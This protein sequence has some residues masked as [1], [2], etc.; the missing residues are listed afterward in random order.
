MSIPRTPSWRYECPDLGEEA[1]LTLWG[2]GWPPAAAQ[3]ITGQ[4]AERLADC[5]SWIADQ[6]TAGL[7]AP[8]EPEPTGPTAADLA[9]W[10]RRLRLVADELDDAREGL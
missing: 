5:L 9:D 7:H 4:L 3:V 8:R 6:E 2:S 1:S 10:S